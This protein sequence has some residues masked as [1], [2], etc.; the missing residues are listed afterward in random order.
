MPVRIKRPKKVGTRAAFPERL[1]VSRH[2]PYSCVGG[3]RSQSVL[4]SKGLVD[5]HIGRMMCW[6]INYPYPE[7]TTPLSSDKLD[8]VSIT[9]GVSVR[10]ALEITLQRRDPILQHSPSIY[11][12]L[13]ATINQQR[14]SAHT[15]YTTREWPSHV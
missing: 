13:T 6:C 3:R 10:T 4:I 8:G 7:I 12:C 14:H 11:S 15:A 9:V 5:L 2:R 1:A